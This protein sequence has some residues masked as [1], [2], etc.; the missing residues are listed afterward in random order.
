LNFSFRT[1]V[2][3]GVNTSLKAI[4]MSSPGFVQVGRATGVKI[5][6]ANVD[7]SVLPERAWALIE[8]RG[9]EIAGNWAA[10]PRRKGVQEAAPDVIVYAPHRQKEDLAWRNAAITLPLTII[11]DVPTILWALY[12]DYLTGWDHDRNDH[13]PGFVEPVRRSLPFFRS[14]LT[15]SLF[16]KALLEARAPG[17]NFEVC[18]LCIDTKAIDEAGWRENR[19]APGRSVLWQHRW[20]TDKN[21][22][23]ALEILLD[24][25]PKY[26]DVTFYLGRKENWDEAI[27]VPQWLRDLYADQA[28]EIDQLQNIHYSDYF[29]TQEEYWRFISGIEISF[30]CSYHETFGIAMLE[31]A[32]AGAACVVPNRAAYP[33][34][35]AGALITLRDQVGQGIESLLQKPARRTEVAASGKAN[36]ARFSVEATV[37]T[38]LQLVERSLMRPSNRLSTAP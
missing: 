30:S 17:T 15:N 29:Q 2:F 31:Q 21:L 8:A 13:G 32:Y 10:S 35:H 33:E 4:A 34:V 1:L 25:G 9:H 11:K 27:W 26:P 12:P 16:S 7:Q 20:A 19:P 38:L 36:A 6:I 3:A 24:L 18:Y 28:R 37:E 22:Q 23:G 14:T 5:Y